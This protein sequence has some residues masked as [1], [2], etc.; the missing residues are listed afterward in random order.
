[1]K[2]KKFCL[3]TF[4]LSYLLLIIIGF[5]YIKGARYATIVGNYNT[6]IEL[7]ECLAGINQYETLTEKTFVAQGDDPWLL[8]DFSS[9]SEDMIRGLLIELSY[10]IDLSNVQIFY[11]KESAE[12]SEANSNILDGESRII[13]VNSVIALEGFRY[14][15]LDINSDFSIENVHIMDNYELVYNDKPYKYVCMVLICLLVSGIASFSEKVNCMRIQIGV[16]FKSIAKKIFI[17]KLKVIRNMMIPIVL[18]GIFWVC[19]ILY[20]QY[21]GNSYTNIYRV[22][23]FT[24]ILSILIF[25]VLYRNISMRHIHIY[26]FVLVMTIGTITILT[27]PSAA[28]TTWDD[29][30]HYSR[31]AVVSWRQKG[32]ISYAD[33]NVSTPYVFSMEDGSIYR[34]EIREEYEKSLNIIAS[35]YQVLEKAKYAGTIGVAFPAYIPG[36]MGL[37]IGRGI[38]LSFTNTFRLGKWMNLLCYTVLF[39]ISIKIV[40]DRGK[41]LIAVIGA[42]PTSIC[43]ASAY[44]YDWWVISFIV[45]GYALCIRE[46]QEYQEIRL[47]QL[48]KILFIMIIGILPKA[49]YFPLLFPIMFLENSKGKRA[50]Y[51]WGMVIGGM[52]F[53]LATFMLPILFQ[54]AGTGDARGGAEVNSTEQIK[55]ILNNPIQYT[56]ILLGFIRK[57]LSPD[58]ARDYLTYLTYYGKAEYYSLCQLIIGAAVILDN[59]NGNVRKGFLPYEKL[60]AIFASFASIVLVVTALYVSFTPVAY[61]TV[62]GCQYRYILPILFPFLFFVGKMKIDVSEDVKAKTAVV[63]ISSMALIFLYGLYNLRICNFGG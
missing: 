37:I 41:L 14:I 42:I 49:V 53:L 1:M 58:N 33:N 35:E 3:N 48:P 51:K 57:R 43:L 25:A 55:F 30:T 10:P 9:L 18:F 60:A 13:Q 15:R 46:M 11:G 20:V 52:I 16:Q 29:E 36:A 5:V 34:P 62:V 28:G 26:Y 63:S 32:L 61:D 21:K 59:K 7:N 24:C 4:C 45:F 38:G 47:T 56:K 22:L 8:L 50:Y 54:G 39:S 27:I 44:A 19:E 12:F 31:T 17:S 2:N 40:K 6:K 23:N